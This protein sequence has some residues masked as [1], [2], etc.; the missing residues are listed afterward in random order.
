MAI[1]SPPDRKSTSSVITRPTPVSATV[2]TTKPAAAVAMAVQQVAQP[3]GEGR[4][5][6][7]PA[8]QRG[9]RPLRRQDAD[10]RGGRPEGGEAGRQVLDHQAP[11]Q[12]EDRDQEVQSGLGDGARLR[13]LHHRAVR[14][15]E[16]EVGLARP[17]GDQADIDQRAEQRDR[18]RRRLAERLLDP[19]DAVIDQAADGD[20][21][22]DRHA[23][24]GQLFEPRGPAAAGQA[25]EAGLHR[26]QMDDVEQ[27]DVGGDRRQEG[28]LD[29]LDVRDADILRDQEGG[30]PHHR[31]HDL[32]VDGRRHLHRAGLCRRIADPL[33]Q[34]N[35]EGA[36][37]DH[38]GDGGARDDAGQPRGDH[39]RL[40]GPAAQMAE[41]GEGKLDEVVAGAGLLQQRAE[42]HEQKDEVGGD[43]E[44]D[45]EHPFGGEPE[46][47][48]GA[49]V[50][51]HLGQPGTGEHVA[52]K[53]QRD[54]AERRPQGAPRRL[55][56]QRHAGDADRH[57][58]RG[59]QAGTLR[60]L[61]VEGVEIAGRPGAQ[62]GEDP[63]LPGHVATRRPAE[64]RIEG[65]GEE[66]SE[67]EMDR[68]RLGVVED[69]GAQRE[70]QRR[71]DPKLEQRPGERH[72]GEQP[73]HETA[74]RP[75]AE[76]GLRRQLL[77]RRCACGMRRLVHRGGPGRA[78]GRAP[79]RGPSL[80]SGPF[81]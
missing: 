13:Q 78:A 56:Q 69:E 53:D 34:R 40:G 79:A 73:R 48:G 41:Q 54:D 47:R 71:G 80:T 20:E 19:A 27:R 32:A 3:R 51:H 23:G 44:R 74:G 11:D 43:A 42:Q 12:H 14:I 63:V 72:A 60:Q 64:G 18:H 26:L 66:Q 4:A 29:H 30:R 9:Q 16:L 59:R 65:E 36:R 35:G 1:T 58:G 70:G 10:H 28:V 46:L 38:I 49:L 68:A 2:P 22:R 81:P 7:L 55:Q 77:R 25:L 52:E 37:G 17:V 39:R 61:G 62:R 45:A 57:V 76:I 33:H 67:G 5:G 8:E 24:G 15:V 75:G 21:A 6:R 31:R 50:R